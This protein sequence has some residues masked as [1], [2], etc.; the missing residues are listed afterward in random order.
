VATGDRLD[1][2]ARSSRG[3]VRRRWFLRLVVECLLLPAALLLTLVALHACGPEV[4]CPSSV[5]RTTTTN[6]VRRWT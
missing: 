3:M 4:S 6:V 5:C 2:V 1:R